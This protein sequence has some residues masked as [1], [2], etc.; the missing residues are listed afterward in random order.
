MFINIK[1]SYNFFFQL[2]I[3][4]IWGY[5]S[6]NSF[7]VMDEIAYIGECNLTALA[8]EN[9]LLIGTNTI[10]SI[11]GFPLSA[12]ASKSI[13][14]SENYSSNNSSTKNKSSEE[15]KRIH[16]FELSKVS[17]KQTKF[18]SIILSTTEEPSLEEK[19]LFI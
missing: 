1:K 16:S 4:P 8:I 17:T 7:I 2:S 10:P 18:P 15:N 12:T 11:N 13:E 6:R 5:N 9:H 3:T 19:Y 14:N